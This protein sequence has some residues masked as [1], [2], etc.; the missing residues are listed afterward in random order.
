MDLDSRARVEWKEEGGRWNQSTH[1]HWSGAHQDVR[2]VFCHTRNRKKVWDTRELMMQKV[3]TKGNKVSRVLIVEAYW[4]WLHVFCKMLSNIIFCHFQIRLNN[5]CLN[6]RHYKHTQFYQQDTQL[7]PKCLFAQHEPGN[8]ITLCNHGSLSEAAVS[9]AWGCSE[10]CAIK[11][12]TNEDQ[13]HRCFYVLSILGGR[14]L[15]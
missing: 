4:W 15:Q 3:Q 10:S 13:A 11:M 8:T 2:L 7:A 12:I 1:L 14:L 5:M 9:P 6:Y